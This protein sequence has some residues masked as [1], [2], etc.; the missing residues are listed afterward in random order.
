ML[1]VLCEGVWVMIGYQFAAP[2]S[3]KPTLIAV[4]LKYSKSPSRIFRRP[5]QT[6]MEL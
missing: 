3:T 1:W 5:T 4:A 2:R 6:L